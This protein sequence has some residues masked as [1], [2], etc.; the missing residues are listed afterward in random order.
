MEHKESINKFLE[1]VL[2]FS[3]PWYIEEISQTAQEITIILDY[4]KGTVFTCPKCGKQCHVYDH[5]WKTFRHLDW[6]QYKTTIKIKIPRIQCY[7][8]T[9]IPKINWLRKGSKFTQMMEN[10]IID[11]AKTSSINKASKQ[12]RMTDTQMWRIIH[13]HVNKCRAEA[14]FSDLH[15]LGIDETSKKGHLYS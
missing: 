12:L 2:G 5:R 3:K 4:P 10:H 7:Q 6:W 9:L 1:A 15:N 14:D 11:M 8:K 13:Y